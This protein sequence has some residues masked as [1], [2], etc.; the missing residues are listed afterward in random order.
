MAFRVYYL[1]TGLT[2]TAFD[3]QVL[4][5]LERGVRSGMD[6][7]HI[8]FD[9]FISKRKTAYV[10]K[11]RELDSMGVR[12]YCLRQCPPFT[13]ASLL[14]DVK[15]MSPFIKG[16]QQSGEKTVFH[17][18]GHVNAYR[19]VLLK[20]RSP[21]SVSVIADLRGAVTDEARHSSGGAYKKLLGRYLGTFYEGIEHEI[22]RSADH[23]LCVSKSFGDYL[24]A[25]H[26]VKN[27]S[28]IPTFVD[29]SRFRFSKPTRDV[30]RKNIGIS[31][32]VVLVFSGGTAQWQKLEAVI[33]L[34]V[35]VKQEVK[36]LF[37]LFLSHDP[38]LLQKTIGGQIHPNDF[39]VIRV[40]Y[41]DVPGYLCAADVAVLLREDRLTNWVAAPIKFSEYMCCGLPCLVSD[42]VGDTAEVVRGERAGIILDSKKPVPTLSEVR[43]L[44]SVNRERISESMAACYSSDIYVPKLFSL[45]R[46][47]GDARGGGS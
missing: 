12:T 7:V 10:E 17:C 45:Y 20:K 34:F 13:K 1:S 23:I 37:M 44:L 32:R 8:S 40:P 38:S 25:I 29:T 46:A 35:T 26:P 2:D 30:F 33:R 18:R 24:Q 39:K 5:I 4:P 15:R 36:N 41:R 42:K 31:D 28:V 11:R 27:L 3:S 16:L 9:P 21:E 47:F 22:L 14:F 19:G 43:E 6:L